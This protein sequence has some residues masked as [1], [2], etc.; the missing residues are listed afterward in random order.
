MRGRT[1]KLED[2]DEKKLC[3]WHWTDKRYKEVSY[4]NGPADEGA[5]HTELTFIN[6]DGV[7]A[8]DAIKSDRPKLFVPKFTLMVGNLNNGII[9]DIK[10]A[11]E[12]LM[13]QDEIF[14]N[15]SIVD[16][17]HIKI[18]TSHEE[19][20][21]NEADNIEPSQ[22]D[23]NKESHE[24][25]DCCGSGKGDGESDDNNQISKSQIG[26]AVVGLLYDMLSNDYISVEDAVEY[27]YSKGVFY[28]N[29]SDRNKD[30]VMKILLA[31]MDQQNVNPSHI[32]SL[33]SSTFC[34]P[35]RSIPVND[36]ARATIAKELLDYFC[37]SNQDKRRISDAIGRKFGIYSADNP[38]TKSEK[39]ESNMANYTFDSLDEL[40]ASAEVLKLVDEAKSGIEQQL[41]D[42][43][44]A[45]K[46]NESK[47]KTI[48]IDAI[49]D[50]SGQL[51]KPYMSKVTGEDGK[52]N[53]DEMKKVTER[54]EARSLDTLICNLEDLREEYKNKP[55][56]SNSQDEEDP[57]QAAIDNANNNGIAGDATGKPDAKGSESPEGSDT[58][59]GKPGEE[60]NQADSSASNIESK[61][62][63][64]L[65]SITKPVN[66]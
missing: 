3:F 44:Q 46:D 13:V 50:L 18:D 12:N 43:K 57:N 2:S 64:P 61:A 51:N 62:V 31:T 59:G 58:E 35:N 27:G 48:A 22:S 21:T 15:D 60:T 55:A 11:D 49:V 38:N 9:S 52:V 37:G 7:D 20:V 53:D 42:V 4:V 8:S 56:D 16:E 30:K 40:K 54:F 1:Y 29:N 23:S 36:L 63:N 17:A 25:A 39:E 14:A 5:Q 33:P 28:I 26:T 65:S 6:I 47:F 41:D 24:E 19:P 66:K 34:G 10:D 32:D 45:A